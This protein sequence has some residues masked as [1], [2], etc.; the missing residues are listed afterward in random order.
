MNLAPIF[1]S[2]KKSQLFGPWANK[3]CIHLFK[4]NLIEIFMFKNQKNH[5]L[6]HPWANELCAHLQKNI[7]KQN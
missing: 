2:L 1:Y 7:I 5:G 3:F 6:F 4:K